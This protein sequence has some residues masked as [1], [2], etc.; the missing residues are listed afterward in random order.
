MKNVYVAT[1]EFLPD[2]EYPTHEVYKVYAD[3]K[4]AIKKVRKHLA[5]MCPGNKIKEILAE[6]YNGDI[7]LLEVLGSKP[8]DYSRMIWAEIFEM[9]IS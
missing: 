9:A 1:I 8:G 4:A 5:D 6:T 7:D 3:R 2:A